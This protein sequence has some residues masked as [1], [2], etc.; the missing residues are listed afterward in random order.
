MNTLDAY[1]LLV[2]GALVFDGR[3][4]PGR[5]ADVGVRDGRIVL[6][7]RAADAATAAQAVDGRGL[8]LAPGFIDVHTH[9]DLE[10]IRN[11]AMPAKLTQGVTT[12]VVGNCG[13]SATP[14]APAAQVPDPMNLLGAAEEFRYPRFADY[15]AAVEAA[16]PAVNVAALVGHTALR[17]N[18]MDRLDR[19]A[20]PAEVAAMRAQLRQSIA[21]GALGLSTGLAYASAHAAPSSEVLELVRDL[22]ASRIYATHLR[23]EFDGILPAMEEAFQV[24]RASGAPVR[25]SHLKCAGVEN[26]HRS[27]EVLAALER[28][29]HGHDVACDC[30]PYAAS[31][32]TLD[33]KQVT[34]AH[35]ILVTWSDP[36]PE[37]GGR[38]LAEIAAGWDATL[39]EAAQRLMPA[40]AVYHGMHE[41]D[42]R[43]ILAHPLT[44]IGSDGLPR[45]PRPHP[46]LWGTFPRVLG[47][48]ARDEALFPLHTAVHK[49]TGLSARAFGLDGRGEIEPGAW[50]D[51]VLF[52]PRRVRDVADFHDPVRPAAGIV[53][54]WVNG[55]PAYDGQDV[56]PRRHGRF[57]VP[58]D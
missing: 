7:G 51:L 12:V 13:I 6:A 16:R 38:M 29:G 11:P 40:G 14:V 26:W 20:T 54:V 28:A 10:V 55:R 32:S 3:D 45:D 44:M 41:A 25:V 22:P 4:R 50:A 36:H 58:A 27:G 34:D 37:Q 9:D 53:Q 47:H 33:P 5:V 17:Q 31:S 56:E 15:R 49:M 2:R 24:G 19:A 52:D 8:A 21:D 48:Y 46:R 23:D 30:Y 43:R 18:H 35:D 39:L 57:L 1:D 42:V